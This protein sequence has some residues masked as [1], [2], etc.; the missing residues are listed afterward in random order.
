MNGDRAPSV[1]PFN[2]QTF[3]P[4]VRFPRSCGFDSFRATQTGSE[5]VRPTTCQAQEGG[6]ERWESG[7]VTSRGQVNRKE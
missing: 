6:W 5:S 2:D 7:K 1:Y 3:V 4:L